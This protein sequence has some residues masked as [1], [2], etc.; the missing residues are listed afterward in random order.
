MFELLFIIHCFL[1][2]HNKIV[3]NKEIS[4]KNSTIDARLRFFHY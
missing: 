2:G 1:L 3:D 4:I